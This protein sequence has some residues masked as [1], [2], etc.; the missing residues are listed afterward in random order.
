[1]PL[2]DNS[3]IKVNGA[4]S[5]GEQPMADAVE[6]TDYQGVP[7]EGAFVD[8]DKTK[9]D[10]MGTMATQNANSVD[11]DGG[12]IDGAT[13]GINTATYAANQTLTATQCR[14]YVIY[15]TAAATITLPAVA[16]GMSVTIL[17]I[18]D[19]EVSVDPNAS[20]LIYLDGVALD[21]GDKIT[22]TSTAG[23]IAVL[24]YYGADGWYAATNAWTD[25]GA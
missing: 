17:T 3:I 25:G 2:T 13:M 10:S 15:V 5:G 12:T 11:I 7:A 9:L 19:V 20:D 14:G 22:N 24:T 21:D 18:G 8:G 6:N 1:M 16:E 4:P 23:D